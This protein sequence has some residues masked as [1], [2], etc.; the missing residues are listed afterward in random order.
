MTFQKS[1]PKPNLP[2]LESKVASFWKAKDIFNKSV[3]NRLGKPDWRF[4][5]GP[6]FISGMPHYGHIKDFITKDAVPRYFTMQ[7]FYAPRIWGW[8]CHG[9]PVESKVEKTLGIT[10]KLEVEKLGV[11]KYIEEC[12]KYT[13]AISDEWGWYVEKMGRWVDYDHAYR[14]MDQNYMETVWWVFKTLYQKELIYK[15]WRS[16]M[17]STDSAT[18]ISNFEVA[19]DNTYE[20]VVDDAVTIKFKIVEDEN[21]NHK[22]GPCLEGYQHLPKY[23]LSWTTTPWTLPSNFAIAVNPSETYVVVKT[24]VEGGAHKVVW[25]LID[26]PM[27]LE[28]RQ[29]VKME[30][31]MLSEKGSLVSDEKQIELAKH[32][33]E[34]LTNLEILLQ[35]IGKKFYFVVNGEQSE[36]SQNEYQTLSKQAL[37]Q[38]A[39][40][41]RYYYPIAQ[42]GSIELN[43]ATI[44]RQPVSYIDVCADGKNTCTMEFTSK[45]T[46][47]S[48]MSHLPDFLKE[49]TPVSGS[50]FIENDQLLLLA[51]KLVEQNI[52]GDYQIVAT[53]GGDQ[54]AKNLEWEGLKYEQMF[55][56]FAAGKNDLQVYPSDTVTVED[57]TGVLHVAPAF[58]EEDFQL[59]KQ[60]G[61]SFTQDIDDA[62]MLL[63]ETGEFAGMY[64]RDASMPIIRRMQKEGK[65][66]K[67]EKYTHRLPFYR[68]KNPLIYRSQDSWFVNVQDLKPELFA[69]NENINWV[70]EH[71]KEGR[72][73]KG[74][75]SAPDWSISRNR[76]WA[77]SMPVWAPATEGYDMSEVFVAGSRNELRLAAVN[78]ITR[79]H[80]L[81]YVDG[82][83]PET[84]S[85]NLAKIFGT[86]ELK[87]ESADLSKIFVIGDK[88][89]A[90]AVQANLA[91]KLEVESA[92]LVNESVDS[93]K[94]LM[95]KLIAE[96]LGKN[97][98]VVLP[99]NAIGYAKA[100]YEKKTAE[101]S[102]KSLYHD[103]VNSYVMYFLD[104]DRM[105]DLHRPVIDEVKVKHP[106]TGAELNRVT[107]VLDVWLDSG[108]MPYAQLHYPF[109]NEDA[110]T[111]GY[112]ADFI[113]EY[114]AQTRAWFY[115]LHVLGVALTGKNSFKNV[116]TSGVIF[117]T[118]GR[119]MSKTY[120]N[121]PD[122]KITLEKFGGEAIRWY[123][124]TSRLLVGEDI[125]FDE[126]GLQIALREYLLPL[127]NIYS[128]FT[129]YANLHDW[130]PTAELLTNTKQEEHQTV[131]SVPGG[132]QNE[133]YWY[134]VPFANEKI[135]KDKSDIWIISLLQK[136]IRTITAEMD[137]YNM[138]KATNVLQDF[139]STLSKWYVRTNRDRFASGDTQ[140]LETLYYV[141]VETAK[142]TAP[143]TP[144]LA[145]ELYQKLVVEVLPG[146][147]ESIHLADYPQA[148]MEYLENNVLILEQMQAIQEIV[149]VGQSIR[150]QNGLKVRQPLG[151]MQVQLNLNPER[152]RSLE[153]WMKELLASEL[154]I[155]EVEEVEQF[156]ATNTAEEWISQTSSS[157]DINVHIYK[158]LDQSLLLQGSLRE[159]QRQVQSARKQMG[160]NVE[161]RISL[162]LFF[163]DTVR[164]FFSENSTELAINVNADKILVKEYHKSMPPSGEG[165]TSLSVLEEPAA[166]IISKVS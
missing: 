106:V 36:I 142:L 91:A 4:Y 52:S 84:A 138:P 78:K 32:N 82:V 59:G 27:D 55:N 111:T 34:D 46:F 90:E 97:I 136:T 137:G 101:E 131:F 119:K 125:N 64:L 73:K 114:I 26:L 156:S 6:P 13:G 89:L 58:G 29:S 95:A 115:V 42:L 60:F 154:N 44:R 54:I 88:A 98:V 127:W 124:A 145:E 129:T 139:V 67:F 50:E 130:K 31:Y 105:L 14:T 53:F 94:A 48:F 9:L 57:G 21:F 71:L 107:E 18:P 133:T 37:G 163:T 126:K 39:T 75:E 1:E 72:F 123:F 165:V 63:P 113:V 132:E 47:D 117:G 30:V 23:L 164:E 12:Y 70:P 81:G 93:V 141:L 7:G 16:S 74:I 155:L 87:K 38:P 5:D 15:G 28:E 79:V 62:G 121:Y 49:L 19:M 143:F 33:A 110:L 22:V 17:Y 102:L 112:P 99:V 162:E 10:S 146:S 122:P 25:N 56:F 135:R 92:E 160:L 109:E 158:V 118:D 96:N 43:E 35:K 140:A 8:D 41:T 148:D 40:L 159:L 151:K 86:A 108:S 3:S 134:K 128:F 80:F 120:G 103:R 152:D 161:D 51:A 116:Q 153:N 65:L 150:T 68:Y 104:K 45:S 77:T 24:A 11:A 85:K 76:F 69:Q 166:F 61:L 144:F 149:G 100:A 157:G 147:Q 66:Y 20:D 83:S 2:D